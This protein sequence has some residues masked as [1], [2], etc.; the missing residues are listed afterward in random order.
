[1]KKFLEN[2]S[3][4]GDK[5]ESTLMRGEHTLTK[6]VVTSKVS[7][8]SAFTKKKSTCLGCKVVL[9]KDDDAV[10]PN[11]LPKMSGIYQKQ[12]NQFAALEEKF[13]RLWTQCQR[14]QG[15]RHEEVLCTSRDCPIFYMRKKIA[16]ELTEQDKV[17]QRFGVPNW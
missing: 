8:L 16:I 12:I 5:A 4:L 15:S 17:L 13:N 9:K 7:A 14:C 2:S 6:T 1:M 11:C 3:I 10:C